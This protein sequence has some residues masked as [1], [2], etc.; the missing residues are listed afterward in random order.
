VIGAHERL[1]AAAGLRLDKSHELFPHHLLQV[2]S[3][4]KDVLLLACPYEAAL[5]FGQSVGEHDRHRVLA[6]FR[7]GF[8]R[9]SASEFAK[10]LDRPAGNISGYRLAGNLGLGHEMPLS[11]SLGQGHAKGREGDENPTGGPTRIARSYCAAGPVGA[12]CGSGARLVAHKDS[13]TC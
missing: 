12:N 13:L 2:M 5:A 1:N 11:S 4:V 6:D 7:A 9:S 3:R 8:D 10:K